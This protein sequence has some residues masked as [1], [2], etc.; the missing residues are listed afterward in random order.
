[1]KKISHSYLSPRLNDSQILPPI[2]QE[3]YNQIFDL[4][5]ENELLRIENSDL[6]KS[7]SFS[8]DNSFTT[9]HKNFKS[10]VSGYLTELKIKPNVNKHSTDLV[11]GNDEYI[12]ETF[13]KIFELLRDLQNDL[14]EHLSRKEDMIIILFNA[15]LQDIIKH[16][17]IEKKQK[18]EQLERLLENERKLKNDYD[19]LWGSVSLIENKNSQLE[20]ENKRLKID[21]RQ[22]A[23]EIEGLKKR[24]FEFKKS[25]KHKNDLSTV[26]NTPAH[27]S[28]SSRIVPFDST[29]T[30][31][32]QLRKS[33][34]E[35]FTPARYETVIKRLQKLLKIEKTN[36]KEF[37]ASY[38]NEISTRSNLENILINC[39]VEVHS[40]ISN[41]KETG[42]NLELIDK[43]TS[44]L[45][46]LSL[47]KEKL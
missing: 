4:K 13:G 45:E 29:K 2:N 21:L 12:T 7:I 10:L 25:E 5:K 46:I 47:I 14:D 44:N 24:M 23:M 35:E 1:M 36:L 28:S 31:K 30:Q 11:E 22:A 32:I 9:S 19:I 38:I 15:R 16:I 41:Y 26:Y 33:S 18:F 39:I 42:N 17:E 27:N 3:K 37:K 20:K 43:L 6:H 34:M 8:R 40:Q